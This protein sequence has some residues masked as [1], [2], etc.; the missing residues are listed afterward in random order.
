MNRKLTLDYGIRWDLASQSK[1][2]YGRLGEFDPLTPNAN[3]GGHP[4][5]WLTVA[6]T[7][8]QRLSVRDR[9]ADRRRLSDHQ[10]NRVPCRMGRG[11]PICDGRGRRRSG[12]FARNEYSRGHQ[13]LREYPDPWLHRYAHVAGHQSEQLSEYRH[14]GP[15]AHLSRQ[16]LHTTVL[17]IN[18]WSIGFQREITR[19]LVF[20]AAYVANRA[21]W[22][23]GGP[24]NTLSNISPAQYAQYGLYPYPEWTSAGT[25]D[26]DFQLLSQAISAT[27]VKQRLAVA[28][29]PNG[30][31]LLPYTGFP[32]STSLKNTLYPFPCLKAFANG[33]AKFDRDTTPCRSKGR[34]A[35]WSPGQ[36][37]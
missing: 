36:R 18:Q 16:E 21:V 25:N 2:T 1:E 27:Q 26:G 4:E 23:A 20:E 22:L 37:Q 29:V 5:R 30:G 34:S 31:L 28:G 15:R 17:R 13:C 24:G 12:K 14:H 8:S 9:S 6:A 10:Q 19:N 32:T 33:I 3:A 11:L 35:F 7:L